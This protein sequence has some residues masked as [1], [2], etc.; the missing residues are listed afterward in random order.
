MKRYNFA[1]YGPICMKFGIQTHL[2]SIIFK[3]CWLNVSVWQ[4]TLYWQ[5]QLTVASAKGVFPSSQVLVTITVRGL[6]DH[7]PTFSQSTYTATLSDCSLPGSLLSMDDVI[8]VTDLDQVPALVHCCATLLCQVLLVCNQMLSVC[9]MSQW[10]QLISDSDISRLVAAYY[11][12][13]TPRGWKAE[14]A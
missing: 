7:K 9:L 1:K 12:L 10:Q 3:M 4:L 6:N 8:T 2:A 13:S 11:S 14:L 5:A